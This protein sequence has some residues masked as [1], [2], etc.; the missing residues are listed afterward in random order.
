MPG[1]ASYAALSQGPGGLLVTGGLNGSGST[2]HTQTYS[3]T[4]WTRGPD[5]PVKV[6]RH[7]Q[8][9]TGQADIVLGG[10]CAVCPIT[11]YLL[12]LFTGGGI[13]GSAI[14][15]N[16]ARVFSL[17]GGRW[18][19]LA[20]MSTARYSP[21]CVYH[22]NEVWAIGGNTASVEIFNLESKRWRDGPALPTSMY[23]GQAVVYENQLYAIYPNGKVYLYS[24]NAWEKV[25]DIQSYS[26]R[27]IFPAPVVNRQILNC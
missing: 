11:Q 19:E 4:G 17:Q 6:M 7:C 10:L 22:K 26:W 15:F 16:S 23:W 9:N 13:S 21:A 5:L 14:S 2:E 1:P 8:V 3:S 27:P 20:A 24:E 12:L 25:A 18:T